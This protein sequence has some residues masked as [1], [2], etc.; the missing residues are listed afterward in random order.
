MAGRQTKKTM[1]CDVVVVGGGNA[2]L[3]AAIA[4]KNEGAKVLLIEKGP[5]ESR[6]G[7]SRHSWAGFRIPVEDEKDYLPLLEGTKLPKGKIEIGLFSKDEFYNVV[8][9]CSEGL[10]DKRLSEIYVSQALETVRWMKK[11][12][13]RWDLSLRHGFKDGDRLIW[14]SGTLFLTSL[15]NSGE[16]LVEQLYGIVE[17]RG[18]EVLYR[19]DA[20]S[21]M[22]NAEGGVCGVFTKGPDG[23][24]QIESKN[25][26]LACGGF[27]ADPAWRRSYL[28]ENWDLVKLRGTHYNTGDGIKMALEIGAQVTGHWGGCHATVVSEDSPMVEG[29]TVGSERYSYLLSI[30]VNRNGERF[31]DEG[32]NLVDYTYAKLG[33]EILKQPSGIVF[34]IFDSK[35]IHLLKDE[36]KNALM[37][38]SNSLE[39][40]AE[41]LDIDVDR[42]MKTVKEFNE[43]IVNDEKPFI[44]YQ[45]DGRRT[46][47]LNPDK[48]NWAQKIDK[49]PF[50]AFAAVCGLT[51]TYGGLKTNEKAQVVDTSDLPIKGLYAVGEVTGGYFYHNYPG[52][53]G[54][55]RGAVMGKIAGDDTAPGL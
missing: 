24:I 4:A 45:L 1:K 10:A 49:P 51:M 14:S 53:A 48:M 28:G 7:N 27:Q 47:G 37:V 50:R 18:V 20:R 52:G 23:M 15:G 54:L 26:I 40:L 41:E 33:K 55:I 8:M 42:F 31:F 34:Q 9:K 36:Y 6:G 44:W 2:G 43:A 38:E 35:V 17:K 39:E 3:V 21:L 32:E 12:G 19:T 25:V 30:M 16:T 11:Q 22:M 13:F 5:K 29:A 46:K